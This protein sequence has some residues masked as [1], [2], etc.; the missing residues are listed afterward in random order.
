[1]REGG[2]NLE[3]AAREVG[4][5]RYILQSSAFRYASGKGFA[6]ENTEFDFDAPPHISSGARLYSE[7]EKRAFGTLGPAV[8]VVRYGFFYGPQTWYASDG[9]IAE[10]VRQKS[11][12]VVQGGGRWSFIHVEDAA[13]ATATLATNGQTGIC[14]IVDDDPIAMSEWL[15]AYAKWV[16]APPPPTLSADEVKDDRLKYYATILRGASNEKAK[17]EFG[18]RPRR[19]EWLRTEATEARV[20]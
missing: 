1:M 6:D 16:G 11:Y 12:P 5:K 3:E 20:A 19:L 15:P 9:D 17:R 4:V 7:V 14:N 13:R 10:Q 8:I 18:F 2:A